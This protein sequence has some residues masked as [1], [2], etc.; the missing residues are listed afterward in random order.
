MIVNRATRR[1]GDRRRLARAASTAAPALVGLVYAAAALA[2]TH[3]VPA[4]PSA[5]DPARQA[6]ERRP[7]QERRSGAFIET[8]P[9]DL[10]RVSKLVGIGVI[11]E[12]TRQIGKIDDVVLD[13]DGRA[14]AV[15]IGTGGFLGMGEKRVGVPFESV[16]WNTADEAGRAPTPDV[17]TAGSRPGT[18]DSQKAAESMP[19][20]R[21]ANESLAAQ[22]VGESGTVNPATGPAAS[23]SRQEPPATDIVVG[24]RGE[25]SRA[26]VRLTRGDLEMAPAFRYAGEDG[27]PAGRERP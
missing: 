21:V 12:E 17:V 16:L 10:M 25:A 2:Q 15:V 14:V 24:R 13:R 8:M 22:N 26:Q 23:T 4:A 6:A 27:K 20:A 18:V 7:A 3:T 1:A 19:G 9:N 11:G 5:A